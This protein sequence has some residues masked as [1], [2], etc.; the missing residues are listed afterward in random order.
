MGS[1]K[2]I[3]TVC[4]VSSKVPEQKNQAWYYAQSYEEIRSKTEES[5]GQ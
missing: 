5:R 4:Y 2:H 1:V 3:L